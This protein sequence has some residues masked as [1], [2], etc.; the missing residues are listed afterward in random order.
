MTKSII[1]I[2]GAIVSAALLVIMALVLAL[3][4]AGHGLIQSMKT[5]ANIVMT[6]GF[7]APPFETPAFVPWTA[8]VTG[9][10]LGLSLMGVVV[11]WAL[12][13]LK[14]LLAETA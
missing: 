10:V 5:V 3:A 1:R 6:V 8:G 4:G 12:V 2:F 14:E 13:A 7:Y 9:L 11:A